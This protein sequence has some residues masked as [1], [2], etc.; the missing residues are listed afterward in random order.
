MRPRLRATLIALLGSFSLAVPAAWAQ[1][2]FP[3]GTRIAPV[4]FAT[5]PGSTCAQQPTNSRTLRKADGTGTFTYSIDPVSGSG[6]LPTGV[7]FN[8]GTRTLS[9]PAAGLTAQ[10]A[11][12]YLYIV[13]DSA[14]NSTSL[15]FTLEIVDEKAVLG[16]FYTATVATPGRARPMRIPPT[17]GQ[18]KGP[19]PTP[20]PPTPVWTPCTASRSATGGYSH[21]DYPATTSRDRFPTSA[22]SP[23]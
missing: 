22:P 17:T 11:T 4:V 23:A 20:S 7:T 6:S 18:T 5:S 21:S 10:D 16:A 8:A 15:R 1:P 2:S 3:V 19:T 13:T 12:E 9:G 14:N